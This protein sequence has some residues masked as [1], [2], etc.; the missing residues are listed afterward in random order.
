MRKIVK[1]Y[2]SLI[3]ITF[4][5]LAPLNC[6]ATEYTYVDCSNQLYTYESMME[7]MVQLATGHESIMTFESIGAT[8]QGRNIWLIKFGNLEADNKILITASIHA[9]EYMTSQLVMRMLEEYA[10]NYSNYAGFFDSVC[11]YIL[12][13]VNPDGVTISQFGIDGKPMTQIKS[14]AN[15]VDLN[16]NFPIGFNNERGAASAPGLGHYPGLAPLSE[17]ETMAIAALLQNNDFV[18]GINYH[19]MGNIVYYGA[20]TN[21]TEVANGCK[22][23]ATL[24]CSINGYRAKYCG[25]AIGSFADYFGTV[26]AAPSVTIEIGTANPVPISQFTD[27]YNKNFLIWPTVANLY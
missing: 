14:N 16:R 8:I 4:M 1:N 21:T 6:K 26:E 24:V 7:D 9:R 3:L 12:P 23:M 18:T 15:G 13:M 10:L 11:F 2:S 17:F 27:I 5:L 20:S 19:S 22:N 25:E